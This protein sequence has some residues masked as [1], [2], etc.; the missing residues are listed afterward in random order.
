MTTSTSDATDLIRAEAIAL[1][2]DLCRFTNIQEPWPAGARLAEFIAAGR[3]GEMAWMADTADRRAHPRAMWADARSA[4]V[5]GVNYGPDHDALAVLGEH[6]R[7]AVS[8]MRGRKAA[9]RLRAAI[10]FQGQTAR[11]SSQP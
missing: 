2:F 6:T 3:H 11:Q 1:G 10:L 9:S 8:S 7:G 5:L 4:I